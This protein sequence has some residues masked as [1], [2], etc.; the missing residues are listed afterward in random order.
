MSSKIEKSNLKPYPEWVC[1]DCGKKVDKTKGRMFYTCHESNC[2][3][4]GEVK[5]VTAVRDFGYPSF[6]GHSRSWEK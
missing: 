6:E 3:V 5:S 1:F 4:C 2:D